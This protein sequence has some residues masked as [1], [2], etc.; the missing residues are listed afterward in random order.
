MVWLAIN[1]LV[2][3]IGGNASVLMAALNAGALAF[4]PFTVVRSRGIIFHRSDQVSATEDY[5]GVIS[6]QVVTEA[7]SSVGIGSI[8]T[9]LTEQ[10]ADFFVFEPFAGT[11]TVQGGAGAAVQQGNSI[12]Q[13]DSKAMRKVDIDD[14]I[15]LVAQTNTA[16][17]GVDLRI[18]GRIL[19]KLH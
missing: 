13:F 14:D 6:E 11:T 5:D 16:S 10:S 12:I 4:R 7:A 8:P 19:I 15:V 3:G 18:T 2:T 17:Q 1:V 9:P